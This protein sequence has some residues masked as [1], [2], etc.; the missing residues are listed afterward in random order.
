MT[1]D[2]Q[3]L[4]AARNLAAQAE[5]DPGAAVALA[6]ELLALRDL[7]HLCK[8]QHR[9]PLALIRALDRLPAPED[10]AAWR[11]RVAVAAQGAELTTEGA[12]DLVALARSA[13]I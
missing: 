2:L 8:R 13:G 3:T 6:A 7:H 12:P 11:R 10:L 9:L 4:Q 1:L 5:L